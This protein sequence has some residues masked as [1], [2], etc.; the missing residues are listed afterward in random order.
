MIPSLRTLAGL[1]EAKADVA[2]VDI[3]LPG[4][5]GIECINRIKTA[6]PTLVCLVLTTFDNNTLIYD[7]LKGGVSV[8]GR[9]GL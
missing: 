3:N 4:I 1:G 6:W 7:A 2:L 9:G 8:G 5:S